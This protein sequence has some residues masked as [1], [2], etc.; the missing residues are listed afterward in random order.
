[1]TGAGFRFN[2]LMTGQIAFRQTD[3]EVGFDDPGAI[4]AT[5]RAFVDIEDMD[6]YFK[7]GHRADLSAEVMMPVLGGQFLGAG[8]DFVLFG[9]Q[10]STTPTAPPVRTMAYTVNLVRDNKIYEMRGHKYIKRGWPWQVWSAT[11]TMHV[12]LRDRSV[13][14]AEPDRIVAAGILKLKLMDFCKQ[15]GTMKVTGDVSWWKK[16]AVKLRYVRY[17]V[18]SLVKSYLF[19]MKL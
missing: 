14:V 10:D 4:A 12:T 16:P 11:T 15:L 8:G 1:M 2:E 13:D 19:H 9:L 5:F 18:W 3:P 7:R 6:E 17:F